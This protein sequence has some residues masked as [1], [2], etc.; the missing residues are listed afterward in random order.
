MKRRFGM[1]KDKKTEDLEEKFRERTNYLRE[2]IM[3][4]LNDFLDNPSSEERNL[5]KLAVMTV[6]SA[7]LYSFL[8]HTNA[9]EN[10]VD[11]FLLKPYQELLAELNKKKH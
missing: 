2:I 10:V 8:K 6:L 9:P 1:R 5:R 7:A 4:I 3:D 11:D